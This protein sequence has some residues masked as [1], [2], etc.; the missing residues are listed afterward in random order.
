M[1][2]EDTLPY[3]LLSDE[4]SGMVD[5]LGHSRLKHESLKTTLKEILDSKSQD[6]IEL[7]LTLI[8][9]TVSVHPPKQ[10]LSLKNPTGILFV[11]S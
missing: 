10:G 8:Q 11:K 5:R 3:M 2:K 7:V 9:K 4:H 6:I 1:Q